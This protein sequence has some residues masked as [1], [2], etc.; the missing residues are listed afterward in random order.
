[1]DYADLAGNFGQFIDQ[2]SS[3]L[4]SPNVTFGEFLLSLLVLAGFL[5]ISDFLFTDSL[6]PNL[7]LSLVSNNTFNSTYARVGA[8]VHEVDLFCPH[9]MDSLQIGDLV[10]AVVNT[11]EDLS[12]LTI[13]IAGH[14]VPVTALSTRSYLATYTMKDS[15]IP[16]PGFVSLEVSGFDMV[17]YQTTLSFVTDGPPVTFSKL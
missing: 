6:T 4:L 10:T 5:A 3:A 8:F 13:S 17:A 14:L 7:T 1:M 16:N 2:T 15:D 12:A 9:P 11:S